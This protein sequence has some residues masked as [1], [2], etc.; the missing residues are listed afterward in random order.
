MAWVRRVLDNFNGTGNSTL[1]GRTP[2]EG[3][4][5]ALDEGNTF[6]L[7]TGG[8]AAYM[9]TGP[10]ARSTQTLGNDQAAQ[11][12]ALTATTTFGAAVGVRNTPVAGGGGDGYYFE[13]RAGNPGC[14]L[15]RW[16]DGATTILDD[17]EREQVL[18]QVVKTAMDDVAL[19]PLFHLI[20][21]WA[22]RRELTYEARMDEGTRAM[23]ARPAP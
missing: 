15:V 17:A 20:N 21:T 1:D 19:I 22:T 18:H 8:N 10:S 12:V 9:T 11:A 3:A 16:D 23:A 4:V 2:D 14:R 13:V 5:W 7:N 6:R